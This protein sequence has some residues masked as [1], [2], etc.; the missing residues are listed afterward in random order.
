MIKLVSRLLRKAEEALDPPYL[1]AK[2]YKTLFM[3]YGYKPRFDV[4]ENDRGS[5]GLILDITPETPRN[6]PAYLG[7]S[8]TEK[9]I[10]H[11][12]WYAMDWGGKTVASGDTYS[13]A[14]VYIE[15]IKSQGKTAHTKGEAAK[16]RDKMAAFLIRNGFRDEKIWS[17][18]PSMSKF[19]PNTLARMPIYISLRITNTAYGTE[20]EETSYTYRWRA[21]YFNSDKDKTGMGYGSLVVFVH[22]LLENTEYDH[23]PPT[24]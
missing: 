3:R 24:L 12:F 8:V 23:Q 22:S 20:A 15:S 1:L 18:S 14:I 16:M 5:L 2:K 10:G 11:S 17:Y 7:I 13:S 21:S 6:F 4:A 19:T 9:E